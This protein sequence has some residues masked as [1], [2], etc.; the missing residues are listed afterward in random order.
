MN[1]ANRE[2]KHKGHEPCLLSA[3]V[4]LLLKPSPIRLG[5]RFPP[6]RFQAPKSTRYADSRQ[7]L[8]NTYSARVSP[9]SLA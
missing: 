7:L 1:Y 6:L 9:H 2:I 8:L 3:A 5:C 4:H